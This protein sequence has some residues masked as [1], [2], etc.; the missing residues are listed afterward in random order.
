LNR[1]RLFGPC[2]AKPANQIAGNKNGSGFIFGFSSVSNRDLLTQVMVI[3]SN[4]DTRAILSVNHLLGNGTLEL[5]GSPAG[6][7]EPSKISIKPRI[8]IEVLNTTVS[9]ISDTSEPQNEAVLQPCA[10]EQEIHECI[11]RFHRMC[12][13]QPASHLAA[14]LH[15]FRAGLHRSHVNSMFFTRYGQSFV[16]INIEFKLNFLRKEFFLDIIF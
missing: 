8:E 4:H 1:I 5:R 2:G 3:G 15:D 11:V 14:M 9:S 13:A 7:E 16:L 12:T 6:D 10:L